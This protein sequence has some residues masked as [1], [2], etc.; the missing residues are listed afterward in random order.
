MPRRPA[1]ISFG[2]PGPAAGGATCWNPTDT[3]ASHQR[4]RRHRLGPPASPHRGCA[5][6]RRAVGA[7]QAASG[8]ELPPPAASGAGTAVRVLARREAPVRREVLVRGQGGWYDGIGHLTIVPDHCAGPGGRTGDAG[9]RLPACVGGT[10]STRSADRSGHPVRRAL[11]ENRRNVLRPD[12][13]IAAH[14]SRTDRASI[15]ADHLLGAVGGPVGDSCPPGP[16][17]TGGRRP[18][19][20]CAGRDRGH[21]AGRSPVSFVS[22]RCLV[23]ADGL[24]RMGAKWPAP[25]SVAPTSAVTGKQAYFH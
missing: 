2:V 13:N 23:P 17:T 8:G 11:D 10:P 22:R 16:V 9:V 5:T 3:A 1:A 24:V 25:P 21:V 4:P 15:G 14:R 20:Q 7:A 19:D 12:Y 6:G 18:D